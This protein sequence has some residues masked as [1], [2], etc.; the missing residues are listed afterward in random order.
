MMLHLRQ[1]F[2]CII[3]TQVVSSA[4]PNHLLGR[5]PNSNS[6]WI[7]TGSDSL[8]STP[9]VATIGF[10]TIYK[11]TLVILI[12]TPILFGTSKEY[13]SIRNSLCEDYCLRFKQG[14]CFLN[15]GDFSNLTSIDEHQEITS[16]TIWEFHKCK[17]IPCL[18]RFRNF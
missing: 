6:D 5:I 10:S 3:L 9:K 18:V 2:A 13:A 15:L 11:D 1:M 7:V 8:L 17:I 16:K 12:E 14:T 4:C